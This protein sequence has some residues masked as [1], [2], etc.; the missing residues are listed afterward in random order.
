MSRKVHPS[1]GLLDQYVVI[2]RATE[3]R[4]AH[5]GMV[6]TWAAIGA[7]IPAG[8]DPIRSNEALTADQIQA[9]T[10]HKITLRGYSQLTSFSRLVWYAQ[11]GTSR[12]F[13]PVGPL[14][15]GEAQAQ[16]EVLCAEQLAGA[17]P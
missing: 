1:S 4:D 7:A 5:G 9:H 6:R 8:I 14:D 10:T 2:E 17:T 12:I 3:T 11:D 13:N 16:V 15:V